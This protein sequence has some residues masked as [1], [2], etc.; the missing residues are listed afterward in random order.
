MTTVLATLLLLGVLIFVHELGHYWAAKAV[1]VGVERFSIG[2]GPRIWGF[3]RRGTEYVI[4]A[5]PLGGYVRMQGMERDV[6]E[7]IGGS[8]PEEGDVPGP[9]D[10]DGKSLPARAFVISAGV[11]MNVAFAFLLY[12]GIAAAWG[13]EVIAT[14]RVMAVEEAALPAGAEP[15]ADVVPG[16][17][18]VR[19]G[20]VPIETMQDVADALIEG[21]PGPVA[22]T[23]TRPAGVFEIVLSDS[24]ED[25]F[26]TVASISPW[27]DA[28][29]GGLVS[30]GPADAGGLEIGDAVTSVDGVAVT[31]WA[32]MVR[33]IEARP[34]ERVSIGLTRDGE[35]L[36]RTVELG[37]TRGPE[38]EELG[39]LGVFPEPPA[40][41]ARPVGPREAVAAGFDRTV[42]VSGAI[43]GF[44]GDLLTRDASPRSVGSIGTIMEMSGQAAERGL[45]EYL[46]F[47]ALF[48]VN[49]A[50]LNLLPIPILDGG[51]LAFLGLE[52]VRGQK[53]S[54]KQR[55]RLSQVGI[56]AVVLLMVWALGNDLLRF[57]G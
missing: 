1:G 49:L 19:V 42:Q 28:A 31:S 54:V 47:M 23:T 15:L 5:I 55:V 18:I 32:E 33:E 48:S 9:G 53:L 52:L 25:R 57:L 46:G 22:V 17:S 51:H 45:R 12:A 24:R 39:Q 38:G 36:A 8:G 43:L 20:D 7:H 56:W 27:F 41:V 44:L 30:G 21:A 4:A 2:L 16:A 3:T 50:I 26:R 34:G 35:A 14:T 40:T 13:D 37:R 6:M 29:V 10:F 11:I